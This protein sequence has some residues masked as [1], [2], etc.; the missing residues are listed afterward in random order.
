MKDLE[1]DRAKQLIDAVGKYTKEL[2]K[3]SMTYQHMPTCLSN[4]CSYCNM[5]RAYL[6]LTN[7]TKGK[8][9]READGRLY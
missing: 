1:Y 6:N 3:C 7:P 5:V 4:E 8:S 2:G 9:Q